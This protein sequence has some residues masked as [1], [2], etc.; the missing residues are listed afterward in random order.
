MARGEALMMLA[1]L[2]AVVV[3]YSFGNDQTESDWCGPP[4]SWSRRCHML[5]ACCC[6][7]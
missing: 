7:S 2:F 5:R 4:C 6:R 1:L 3:N